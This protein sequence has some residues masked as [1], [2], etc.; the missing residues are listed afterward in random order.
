MLVS[1]EQVTALAWDAA[2]SA[3]NADADQPVCRPCW[4]GPWLS[5][6]TWRRPRAVSRSSGHG[7][8]LGTRRPS[9]TCVG[10]VAAPAARR[11]GRPAAEASRAALAGSR[12]M[13]TTELPA[14][15]ESLRPRSTELVAQVAGASDSAERR[16]L[17]VEHVCWPRTGP[18][19]TDAGPGLSSSSSSTRNWPP[20]GSCGRRSPWGR[21][22]CHH[23]RPRHDEQQERF[24]VRRCRRH[25]LVP[26]VQRA[27]RGSDLAALSTRAM[28]TEAAS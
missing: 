13:L 7:L 5:T 17:I 6:P 16:R 23:H 12:R 20:P 3:D 4:P 8:H 24:V 10:S 14:D 2:R 15:A 26:A 22:P 1:V 19:P 21:G 28:K 18:S 25:Q 9:A 11:L 27:R